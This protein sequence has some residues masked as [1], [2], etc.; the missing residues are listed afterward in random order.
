MYSNKEASVLAKKLKNALSQIGCDIKHAQAL[1]VIARMQGARNLHVAQAR[2]ARLSV[3]GVAQK[4]AL[5]VMFESLGRYAQRDA[6][7]ITE[8][9]KVE[10]LAVESDALKLDEAYQSL[11]LRD[12]SPLLREEYSHISVEGLHAAFQQLVSTL[13]AVLIQT[14]TPATDPQQ[15]QSAAQTDAVKEIVLR[16]WRIANACELP[17]EHRQP[18]AVKTTSQEDSLEVVAKPLE[19]ETAGCEMSAVVEIN[20]GVPCVHLSNQAFGDMVLTVFATQDGL[21]LR[22]QDDTLQLRTGRPQPSSLAKLHDLESFGEF[23]KLLYYIEA[24]QP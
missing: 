14:S 17:L 4:Q 11:L 24:G 3:R 5:A 7:L 10:A 12:D 15:N 22:L 19:S 9:V 20:Q 2:Q 23:G 18:Y 8:L 16:D 13:E 6:A 21:L 1:E